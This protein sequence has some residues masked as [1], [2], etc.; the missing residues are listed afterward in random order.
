MNKPT[1]MQAAVSVAERFAE[2]QASFE[3]AHICRCLVLAGGRWDDAARIGEQLQAPD[4][5]L[6]ILKSAVPG[7]TTDTSGLS[8]DFRASSSAFLSALKNIGVVETV[9]SQARLVPPQTFVSA[10]TLAIVGNEVGEAKGK[11]LSRLELTPASLEKQ[12]AVALVVM[13]ADALREAGPAGL[14]F[15]NA[16]LRNAVIAAADQIF[17]DAVTTGLTPLVGSATPSADIKLLLDATNLAS[18][19][20]IVLVVPPPGI[21]SLLMTQASLSPANLTTNGGEFAGIRTVVTDA[22]PGGTVVAIDASGVVAA[23]EGLTLDTARHASLQFDDATSQA[24]DSPPV[25]TTTVNLWQTNSVGLRAERH[26]RF[27]ARDTAVAI[28]T[29]ATWATAA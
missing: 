14:N 3:L 16:E 8:G 21:N 13:T 23:D 25:P 26:F 11:F 28:M 20:R 9:L 12:K 15:V 27:T 6:R 24:S 17:L 10:T 1:P 4:R 29:G 18:G 7:A 22:L 19:S 2:H 5:A